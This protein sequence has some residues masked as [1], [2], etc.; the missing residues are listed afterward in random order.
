MVRSDASA[1]P[2]ARR[3][4]PGLDQRLTRRQTVKAGSA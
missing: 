4:A 3:A 1:I 2:I